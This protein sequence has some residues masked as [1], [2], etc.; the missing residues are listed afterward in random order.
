MSSRN[1]RYDSGYEKRK[2]RQRLEVMAQTQRGTLICCEMLKVVIPL[3]RANPRRVT[4]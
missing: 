4:I 1:R 2:K 3:I